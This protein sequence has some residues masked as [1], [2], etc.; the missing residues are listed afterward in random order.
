MKFSQKELDIVVAGLNRVIAFNEM[1]LKSSLVQVQWAES[2]AKA[3]FEVKAGKLRADN[4]II[5]QVAR[6]LELG[7]K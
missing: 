7:A 5:K 4:H 3:A 2:E 6:W 1:M